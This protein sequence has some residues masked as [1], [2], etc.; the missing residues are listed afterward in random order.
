MHRSPRSTQSVSLCTHFRWHS[1][2]E[3]PLQEKWHNALN[4]SSFRPFLK[5][6][7]F[8]IY[9]LNFFFSIIICMGT[10]YETVLIIILTLIHIHKCWFIIF[11]SWASIWV[12][13]FDFLSLKKSVTSC[14]TFCCTIYTP[15][16]KRASFYPS[17]P[18][19]SQDQALLIIFRGVTSHCCLH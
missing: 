3:L 16:W 15:P 12:C 13:S 10:H 9:P 7:L 5:F 11:F 14:I 1:D 17:L 6:A 2:N 8:C 19:G 4:N 18:N